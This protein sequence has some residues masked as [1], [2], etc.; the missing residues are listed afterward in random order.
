MNFL[1][2]IGTTELIIIAIILVVIFGAAKMR[3]L[4]RGLGESTKEIK[5]AKDELQGNSHSKSES[6]TEEVK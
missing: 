5:R 6:K 2:N 1:N 4:G 3:E